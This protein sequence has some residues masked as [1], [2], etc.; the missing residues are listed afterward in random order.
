MTVRGDLR[1][2]LIDRGVASAAR[3]VTRVGSPTPSGRLLAALRAR[4]A[5]QVIDARRDALRALERR[6]SEAR[7]E[8]ARVEGARVDEAAELARAKNALAELAEGALDELRRRVVLEARGLRRPLARL[9][10]RWSASRTVE[11]IDRPDFDADKRVRLMAHLDEM[12]ETLG[13]YAAFADALSPLFVRGRATRVLDLAAGHAGFTL[14]LARLAKERGLELELTATD[15]VDEYLE[16][17]RRHARERG[18]DVRFALQ[19][20]LDT[21]N[22]ARGAYD[23]IVSTQSLHHFPAGHIAVLAHEAIRIATRG[24]VLIDGARSMLNAALIPLLGVVRYHDLP[25][26]HDSWV[27]LRKFFAPEE[28]G[29]LA[30][31]GALAAGEDPSRVEARFLP[32]GHIVCVLEARP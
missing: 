8:G 16:L 12:N 28:L 31:I 13:A 17:G 23:V 19:D 7:V 5:E 10:R 18:L 21:S 22:L 1:A 30:R 3:L 2:R 25:F 29:L 20:A 27:S 26:A 11:L 24:V 15:L 6:L 32:P 4:I 14:S 9:D